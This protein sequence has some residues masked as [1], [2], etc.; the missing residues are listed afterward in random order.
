MIL[1]H[2][3][4]KREVRSTII[5]KQGS[6]YI[7]NFFIITKSIYTSSAIKTGGKKERIDFKIW[8]FLLSVYWHNED[9][10]DNDDLL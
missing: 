3:E 10:N 5:L 1:F 4:N 9:I 2:K 6:Y 7:S 8:Y